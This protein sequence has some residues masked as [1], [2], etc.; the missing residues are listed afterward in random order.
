MSTK[1][2]YKAVCAALLDILMELKSGDSGTPHCPPGAV[3]RGGDN[4]D[5]CR[6]CW[7]TA[8]MGRASN[9]AAKPGKKADGKHLYGEYG[10]VRLTKDE[11]ARLCAD[12]G[13]ESTGKAIELLDLHIGAKGKDPYA[14]HNLAMR[15]WVFDAVK[16]REAKHTK[17]VAVPGSRPLNY[18]QERRETRRNLAAAI[19]TETHRRGGHGN[20][21]DNASGSFETGH[22]ALPPAGPRRN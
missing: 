2:G 9:R 18:G 13:A 4:G 21:G 19:V 17:A 6:A 10:N 3:C 14:N 5:R 7:Q 8:A 11:Y 1:P 12:F 22:S 15:K 20:F 16:E